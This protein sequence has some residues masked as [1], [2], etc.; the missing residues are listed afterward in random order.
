[1]LTAIRKCL[2]MVHARR[3]E[4]AV[5]VDLRHDD[6]VIRGLHFSPTPAG[7]HA[8]I[9]RAQRRDHP[10][11]HP[12]VPM[13]LRPVKD[14]RQSVPTMEGAGVS[15]RRA[16]GFGNTSEF[17]P[18]L[19]FD[20]FRLQSPDLQETALEPGEAAERDDDPL[21]DRRPHARGAL[22]SRLLCAAAAVC[23]PCAGRLT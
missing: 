16:F 23:S 14:V 13:S 11:C 2:A 21:Q 1:M 5:A 20:D 3:A 7:L 8:V 10:G 9:L 12:E 17:D 19:L 6:V 15:L 18:F 4:V 22:R